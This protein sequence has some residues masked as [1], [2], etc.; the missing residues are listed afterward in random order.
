MTLGFLPDN[1]VDFFL[2]GVHN[3]LGPR[4]GHLFGVLVAFV[5]VRQVGGD[6]GSG[7]SCTNHSITIES[8]KYKT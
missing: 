7:W 1:G 5:G 2:I 8:K 3:T 6:P 4:P